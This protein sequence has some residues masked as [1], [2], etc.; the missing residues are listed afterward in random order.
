MFVRAKDNIKKHLAVKYKLFTFAMNLQG[1]L[2]HLV[3]R[4]VRNLKVVGS[5]PI[6]STD[7]KAF[8]GTPY[9]CWISIFLVVQLPYVSIILTMYVP[10]L[11]F[12][13]SIV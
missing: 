2:A 3:E 5:S 11:K 13:V 4:Q 7:Y 10:P 6:F 8:F 9:F 1:E 12:D